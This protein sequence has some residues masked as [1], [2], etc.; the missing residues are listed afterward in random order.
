M[1]RCASAAKSGTFWGKAKLLREYLVGGVRIKARRGLIEKEYSG[2]RN[3]GN[4][5][6]CPLGL[7]ACNN[8]SK[9]CDLFS[10]GTVA[11]DPQAQ[12]LCTMHEEAGMHKS[13]EKQT[14]CQEHEQLTLP[15]SSFWSAVAT[16]T[17]IDVCMHVSCVVMTAG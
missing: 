14:K 17:P 5:N 1:I 2:V 16:K 7:P 12:C 6:V 8:N 4:P 3:K 11:T 9:E 15:R 13:S 10:S